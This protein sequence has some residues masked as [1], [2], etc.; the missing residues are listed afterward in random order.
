MPAIVL[1]D[2]AGFYF[3]NFICRQL[4]V[5]CRK[6][7]AYLLRR[8]QKTKEKKNRCPFKTSKMD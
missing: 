1:L 5:V 8:H 3:K 7:D 2:L 6:L 4:S